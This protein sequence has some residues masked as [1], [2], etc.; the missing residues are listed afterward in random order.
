MRVVT[1]GI[2]WLPCK[3]ITLHPVISICLS[4]WLRYD[5]LS[6]IRR[7]VGNHMNIKLPYYILICKLSYP[8]RAHN[9]LFQ[10]QHVSQKRCIHGCT[11]KFTSNSYFLLSTPRKASN[12]T[13][14]SYDVKSSC[15]SLITPMPTCV[16]QLAKLAISR[17]E[18][19]WEVGKG[20]KSQW[21]ISLSEVFTFQSTNKTARCGNYKK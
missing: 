2:Q 16:W 17:W 18:Y 9:G 6:Q 12:T 20:K 13:K 4:P 3:H 7:V 10:S 19:R 5:L 14:L 15:D 8:I 21:E 1:H 11:R